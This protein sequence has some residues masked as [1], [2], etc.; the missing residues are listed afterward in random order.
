VLA[1]E[2][3]VPVARIVVVGSWG[4]LVV[5]GTGEEPPDGLRGAGDFW[6]GDERRRPSQ[7]RAGAVAAGYVA[8]WPLDGPPPLDGPLKEQDL[9]GVALAVPAS[10]HVCAACRAGVPG[11]YADG[12]T[13]FFRPWSRKHDWLRNCPS[14]GASADRA[15]LHGMLPMPDTTY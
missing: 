11:L 1:D 8:V 5:Y 13:A 12:G 3:T 15:R 4:S 14:C 9:V 7:L 6:A 10:H 2:H